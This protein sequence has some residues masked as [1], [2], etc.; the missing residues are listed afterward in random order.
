MEFS[1][2]VNF[3][4]TFFSHLGHVICIIW[5]STKHRTNT[6]IYQEIYY[7]ESAYTT[8]GTGRAIPK[9]VGHQS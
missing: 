3:L 1:G 8:V 5:D 4:G 6:F 2:T 9:F 7:E